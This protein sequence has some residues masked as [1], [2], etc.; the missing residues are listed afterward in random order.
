MNTQARYK[1]IINTVYYVIVGVIV[2]ISVKVLF[3]YLFPFIIGIII[4]AMVQKPAQYLSERIKIK[5]G[6]CALALVLFEFLIII[7]ALSYLVFRAGNYIYS[8]TLNDNELLSSIT[9][10]ADSII[11]NFENLPEF[12]GV[13]F[14]NLLNSIA[15]IITDFAKD[16]ITSLPMF[17]TSSLVTIIASCYIAKDYDRFKESVASVTSERYKLAAHK[18]KTLFNENIKSLIVGYLKILAITFAELL[19]G[20]LILKADNAVLYAAL[21]AILDLLPIIGTGTVLVPWAVYSMIIS[22]FSFAVGLLILYIVIVVIRNIIEPKIVGKQIGLHPL[23]ALIAVFI[24]LKLF[25]FIGIFIT[26][27]I[28]MFVYKMF[29]DGIFELLLSGK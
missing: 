26:P 20:L 14:K 24:G 9:D 18:I 5:K 11:S 2:Y 4:T 13:L 23:I 3:A 28:A 27:F 19:V 8:L 16:I 15:A 7:G 21:I 1:F 25:G 22:N 6:Y 10:F 17:I 29:D 12:F